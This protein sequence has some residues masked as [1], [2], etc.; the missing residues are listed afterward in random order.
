LKIDKYKSYFPWLLF[1]F[2]YLKNVSTLM[3]S[4]MVIDSL[5]KAEDLFL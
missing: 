2:L 3:F 1:Q 4:F 5:K